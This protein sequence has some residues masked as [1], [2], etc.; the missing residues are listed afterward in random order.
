MRINNVLT[1]SELKKEPYSQ[2]FSRA[3]FMDLSE[4]LVACVR[5]GASVGFVPPF[6]QAEALAFWHQLLPAFSA[7]DRRILVARINGRIVGTVQLVVA[8]PGNGQHRGDVVKLLVHPDA[9]RQ[10][11]A[12]QLMQKIEALALAAG[13]KLLVLDTVTGSDAQVLY[14]SLGYE[15]SG[16]IPGYALSTEGVFEATSVMYKIIG[17]D[18]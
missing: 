12:R 17:G 3:D 7:G 9:R 14:Q 2:D 11:I 15:L 18:F 1:I 16:T 5:L 10:G 13:K 8:M 4:T 6:G